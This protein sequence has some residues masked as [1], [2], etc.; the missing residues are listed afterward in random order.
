M[1]V[2]ALLFKTFDE[3]LS[4]LLRWK[5]RKQEDRARADE[6]LEALRDA[7]VQTRAYFAD[8]SEDPESRDREQERVLSQCWNNVGM[9]LRRMGGTEQEELY[10][11]CFLKADY[12]ADPS[13]W[14]EI[15]KKGVDIRL[16]AVDNAISDLLR[17]KD[18]N[19]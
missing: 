13:R 7:V 11:R 9:A 12:W 2:E 1:A 18:R 3:T 6:V 14:D 10:E 16:D 4:W 8:T 5:K 19:T 15:K 17:E